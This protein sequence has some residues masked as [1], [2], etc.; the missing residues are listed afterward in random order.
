M[1][2]L[3]EGRVPFRGR[4]TWYRSV[5][6]DDPGKLPLL[7]LHGGPGGSWDYL[8]PLEGLADTGRRVVFY[9]QLGCGNSDRPSDPALWTVELY[10]EEVDVVREA[11]AL[12]RIHLLG[13]SWGGMLA[14]EYAL[15]SPA[16]LA[17]LILA[18]SPASRPQWITETARLRSEL[19][20]EVQRT[21]DEHERAGT[22]DDPAY[23]HAS[24]EFYRRHV[25][26]ADP[27]PD[28]VTDTFAKL[29][30]EIYQTMQGPNEF[31]ITGTLS[32]W[33]ITGR[34]GEIEVPTLV[35][36]GQYDECTPAIAETVHR[37]IRGSEWVLFED[38]SHMPFVERPQQYLE[39]V[40][41]FLSR[42]ESNVLTAGGSA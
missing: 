28:C 5:G 17:S 34:L 26:R 24:M 14:M 19:P 37:G 1:S 30:N 12:D 15:R 11:L 38:C 22:T 7:C 29:N 9:D 8:Q 3:V 31:V 25:C 2:G 10:L 13:S 16:G 23:E 40:D 36:S 33:D 35:T 4:E 20:A 42:V 21:L 6:G 41:T 27:W 18:S 39:A 32:D